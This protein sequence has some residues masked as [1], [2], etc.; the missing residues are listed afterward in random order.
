MESENF[1]AIAT[2]EVLGERP[3]SQNRLS[4]DIIERESGLGGRLLRPLSAALLPPSE[5]EDKGLIDRSKLLAIKGRGR[6]P[7]L[8]L[9]QRWGIAEFATPSGGCLLTEPGYSAKLRDLLEHPGELSEETV[10]LL[11]LGRHFRHHGGA[12]LIVGRDKEENEELG[13]HIT[14]NRVCLTVR[15]TGSPI[16]VLFCGEPRGDVLEWAA[17][18][19]ARYSDARAKPQVAVTWWDSSGNES[20][21]TLAPLGDPELEVWRL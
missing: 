6:K 1:D 17:S 21:L 13:K 9:A 14:D 10:A 20:T 16:G 4:L 3:M 11:G 19:V 18:I 12:K 7:Q 2:G 15:G 8:E 5:V